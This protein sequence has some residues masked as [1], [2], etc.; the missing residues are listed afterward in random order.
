MDAN[1]DVRL[2]LN[3]PDAVLSYESR[4]SLSIKKSNDNRPANEGEMHPVVAQGNVKRI[5]KEKKKGSTSP[6]RG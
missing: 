3:I 6:V 1:V 4:S 5:R 2:V